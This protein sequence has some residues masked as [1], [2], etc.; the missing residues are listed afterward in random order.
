MARPSSYALRSPILSNL[1]I[2]MSITPGPGH[3]LRV[4]RKRCGLW[5]PLSCRGGGGRRG[6]GA[7]GGWAGG[8]CVNINLTMALKPTVQGPGTLYHCPRRL[9]TR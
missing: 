7:Y 4:S 8:D 1:S 3:S 9:R 2:L 5:L 6:G